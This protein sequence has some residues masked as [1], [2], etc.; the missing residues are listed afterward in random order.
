MVYVMVWLMELVTVDV[1]LVVMVYM[2]KMVI[3]VM[4]NVSI[5][6]L[7]GGIKEG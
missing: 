3:I 1:A 6:V 2:V 4:T 7:M 5:N